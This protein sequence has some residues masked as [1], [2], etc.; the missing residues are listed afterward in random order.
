[1]TFHSRGS[2][3]S[4]YLILTLALVALVAC[5]GP[6]N[7]PLPVHNP[8]ASS[9]APAPEPSPPAPTPEPPPASLPG[10][11]I[12]LSGRIF[13]V[14]ADGTRRPISARQV[15]VEVDV[16]GPTDPKRGGWVPVGTDGGYRLSGVPDNRFV[17]IAEVETTGT[18]RDRFCATNTITRGDTELD[19]ALFQPGAVLPTPTISGRITAMIDDKL[20]PIAGAIIYFQ[21]RAFAPDVWAVADS[22]GRYS[23][24]GIPPIPGQLYMICANDIDAYRRAVDIRAD[25]VIDIDATRVYKCGLGSF[26]QTRRSK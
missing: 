2:A 18:A 5:S 16:D 14:S 4:R 25:A 3:L 11:G 20:M 13:E 12:T 22:D 7:F 24:C 10:P 26:L 19:I 21:S 9:P 6:S 8:L 23:L 15:D 17:K 1:M